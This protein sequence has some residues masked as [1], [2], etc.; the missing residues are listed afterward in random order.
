MQADLRKSIIEEHNKGHDVKTIAENLNI[1]VQ[2]VNKIIGYGRD[3][4]VEIRSGDKNRGIQIEEVAAFKRSL[5]IGQQFIYRPIDGSIQRPICVTIK[6]IYP[7]FVYTEDD[8][9]LLYPDL[10]VATGWLNK[11]RSK[12][13]SS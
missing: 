9:A 6:K 5:R 3:G 7:N 12:L 8:K 1:T 11:Y 13:W 4:L 10:M 2:K